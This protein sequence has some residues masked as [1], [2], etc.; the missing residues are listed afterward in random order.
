[1]R[2]SY[3]PTEDKKP[4]PDFEGNLRFPCGKC[5]E[6]LK[7]RASDWALRAQ[8]EIS[9]HPDNCFITLTYNDEHLPSHY[10]VKKDFQDFAKRLR[11]HLAHK[12]IKIMYSGE[13]GSRTY[14]PHF[15][16]IIFG[17]SPPQWKYLKDTPKGNK[18]FTSPS[19]EKLWTK[20]F[21]SLSEA[22]AQTAY[23]IAAYNLKG[24]TRTHLINGEYVELTD[25]FQASQGIGKTFLE[26]NMD[27][28]INQ[29]KP[30]PRYYIKKLQEKNPSLH[31]RYENN[32]QEYLANNPYRSN[33]DRYAT[34][35]YE[36]QKKSLTQNEFRDYEEDRLDKAMELHLK[37]ENLKDDSLMRQLNLK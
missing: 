37:T 24:K 2:A 12:K 25:F 34:Q 20:G 28:L 27:T 9:E 35:V 1:M 7:K 30:L 11:K 8:H 23:Y 21:S 4:K 18:I 13:Y 15:H 31:I 14:R 17:W 3:D 6:C 19:L 32:V 26:K 29:G 10:L 36:M 22:N 5:I 16:A 33:Y